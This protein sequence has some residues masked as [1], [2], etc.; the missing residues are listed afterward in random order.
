MAY[1]WRDALRRKL[2]HDLASGF[3]ALPLLCR[4]FFLQ[5]LE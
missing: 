1:D 5:L 2:P 3:P 4:L